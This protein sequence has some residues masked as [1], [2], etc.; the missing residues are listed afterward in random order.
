MKLLLGKTC[1]VARPMSI[2]IAIDRK[3]STVNDNKY[4]PIQLD[5]VHCDMI[6]WIIAIYF[7]RALL[8]ID[9]QRK[10]NW[11]TDNPYQISN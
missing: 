1:T 9:N 5:L 4:R 11:I 3:I 10:S 8:V 2:G 6:V 7:L